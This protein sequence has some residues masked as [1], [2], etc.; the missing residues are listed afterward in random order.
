MVLCHTVARADEKSARARKGLGRPGVA[1]S[2]SLELFFQ[3]QAP[4]Q[5]CSMREAHRAPRIITRPQVT[6]LG[7]QEVSLSTFH[8]RS[9]SCQGKLLFLAVRGSLL[10]KVS[11]TEFSA[12]SASFSGVKNPY[13]SKY[14]SE[15][16]RSTDFSAI[17]LRGCPCSACDRSSLAPSA[18][19]H[20]QKCLCSCTTTPTKDTLR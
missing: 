16:S 3:C 2:V 8:P 7:K 19:L 10:L 17:F 1:S 4:A 13:N 11:L 6:L 15:H 5:P 14:I 20:K 18:A 9:F 12:G